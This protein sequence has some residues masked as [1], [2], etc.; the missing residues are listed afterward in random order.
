MKKIICLFLA[1]AAL[2]AL[3]AGC[4]KDVVIGPEEPTT[5]VVDEID[6]MGALNRLGPIDQ[7]VQDALKKAMEQGVTVPDFEPPPQTMPPPMPTGVPI[8]AEDVYPLMEKVRNILD[9]GSYMLKARGASAPT[10]G[11]PIGSQPITFAVSGG[12]SAFEAE[13]DWTNM[14]RAMAEPG[15]QDYSMASIR[16]ATM[17]TFFGKKVRF[18]TKPDGSS[19]VFLDKQSYAPIPA[20]EDGEAGENPLNMAGMFGDMFKPEKNGAVTASKVSD[21]GKDYLCAEIRGAEGAQLFYYFLDNN[22]KRIEMKVSNPEDGKLEIFVFEI[23]MLTDKVDAAMFSTAGFK[24][25]SF[26][27][28]AQLGEGGF[29]GLLG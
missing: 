24:A 28:M 9:S 16:G 25:I 22:L 20:G 10:P 3:F 23:D 1:L 19:I 14:L 5:V 8:R 17:A 26:D 18:V 11:M 21:G 6:F 27:E 13:M 15:T 29:G 7:D 4:Q 2:F 12:Q